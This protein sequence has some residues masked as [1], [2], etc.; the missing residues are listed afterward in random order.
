M[1][2]NRVGFV[3]QPLPLYLYVEREIQWKDK[4]E[5]EKTG[6]E[7]PWK[8]ERERERERGAENSLMAKG[9]NYMRP[10]QKTIT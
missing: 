8:E 2:S 7:I 10:N 3:G 4:S 9:V 5:I 1:Q 6:R